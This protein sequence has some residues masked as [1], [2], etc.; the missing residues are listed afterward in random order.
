MSLESPFSPIFQVFGHHP[1]AHVD[2]INRAAFQKMVKILTVPLE[3]E[4]RCIMLSAPRAGY[5][6]T[7]LLNQLRLKLHLSH[8][9]VLVFP[10]QG[11]RVD[12][13]VVLMDVLRAMTERVADASGLT[14]LDRI[15][16]TLLA[17]SLEPLVDSGEL[18]SDNKESALRAMRDQ[19]I[20]TFDF[21]DP[22][23]ITAHWTRDHFDV[24]G[25]RLIIELAQRLDLPL[26]ETA[27]WI[28]ALF[29]F[30]TTPLFD[31]VR[32]GRLLE[33]V[34]QQPSITSQDSLHA[35]LR[36]MSSMRRVVLVADELEGLS[37]NEEGALRF[38]SFI[39]TLRHG[40]RH[41]DVVLAVN[42]DLWQNAFLPR[43]SEGLQDRL[44]EYRVRLQPLK[45]QHVQLLLESRAP[46]M[47]ESIAKQLEID[48]ENIYARAVLRAAT[49]HWEDSI[50]E[51]MDDELSGLVD[52]QCSGAAEQSLAQANVETEI[53]SSKDDTPK[54]N[55]AIAAV[56]TENATEADLQDDQ[57]ADDVVKRHFDARSD[58]QA[59]SLAD[60][61]N[62]EKSSKVLDQHEAS[63]PFKIEPEVKVIEQAQQSNVAT[64]VAVAS[65]FKI[66]DAAR[67]DAASPLP[68]WSA[69]TAHV[70]PAVFD[71]AKGDVKVAYDF[72]SATMKT[73]SSKSEI[74]KQEQVVA[75]PFKVAPVNEQ[76]L[77]T[78]STISPFSTAPIPESPVST[79]VA[80]T[81]AEKKVSSS[82]FSATESTVAD[83]S[84][85]P[86]KV[87]ELLK[88]FRD[89]FGKTS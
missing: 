49:V 83:Q 68:R 54:Q 52:A 78:K 26:K 32:V 57:F 56:V 36:L 70:P 51:D 48:G 81:A 45:E 74:D 24:L 17:M 19:P 43:L 14:S 3:K 72:S 64:E 44:T 82:P 33:A 20:Q 73:G 7:H 85:Q 22:S 80:S 88:K 38:A 69:N 47:S 30:A 66:A 62:H 34:T 77:V 15:A 58:F 53:A 23:A 71:A 6:K 65:P 1:G 16:R 60:L 13:S 61:S 28:E 55:A 41:V 12:A 42:D 40:A 9:L 87:D 67:I 46:G 8:D 11:C 86:D 76:S 59:V 39:A 2:E 79:I 21:H 89:R 10:D 27:M 18:P 63:S 5:G 84:K 50:G 37:T 75:S 25:P 31:A 4:G 29:E 35:L